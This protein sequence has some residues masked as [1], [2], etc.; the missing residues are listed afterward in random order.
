MTTRPKSNFAQ[1]ILAFCAIATL[2]FTVYSFFFSENEYTDEAI[3]IEND[4]IENETINYLEFK[5]SP[6]IFNNSL[7]ESKRGLIFTGNEVKEE[8][9]VFTSLKCALKSQSIY[10]S[11]FFIT[12]KFSGDKTLVDKYFVWLIDSNNRIVQSFAP[13]KI[14][15]GV[16]HI[17]FEG[18]LPD[19][20]Y[21]IEIGCTNPKKRV[22][23]YK[24][25][26]IKI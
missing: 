24:E 16:N 18:R 23:Y 9:L 17:D 13:N 14:I 15:N 19:G 21:T 1:I 3:L 20:S 7:S 10:S 22:Y 2:G 11:K 8:N 12:F 5:L 4:N 25:C 6:E 26:R